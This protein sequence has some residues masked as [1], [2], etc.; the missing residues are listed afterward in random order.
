VLDIGL[1][2]SRSEYYDSSATAKYYVIRYYD[3]H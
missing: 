1:S 3:R 2:G